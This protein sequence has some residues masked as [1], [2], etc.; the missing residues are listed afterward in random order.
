MFGLGCD[1]HPPMRRTRTQLTLKQ[2]VLGS[3]PRGLTSNLTFR[4]SEQL[5]FEPTDSLQVDSAWFSRSGT[6]RACSIVPSSGI[7]R[8]LAHGVTLHGMWRN[9]VSVI[10]AKEVKAR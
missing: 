8:P 4:Y 3:T 5:T 7:A 1:V 2:P 6:S 9:C 10:G